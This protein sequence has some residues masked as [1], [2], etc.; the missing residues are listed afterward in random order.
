MRGVYKT[1]PQW[2][3]ASG[4]IVIGNCVECALCGVESALSGCLLVNGAEHQVSGD[5]DKVKVE[6]FGQPRVTS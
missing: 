2:R 6:G 4:K 3:D 1:I 5:V